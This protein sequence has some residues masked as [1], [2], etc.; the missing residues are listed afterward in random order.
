[1]QDLY[2]SLGLCK[3]AKVNQQ[4]G[5]QLSRMGRQATY[6]DI[7]FSSRWGTGGAAV[8]DKCIKRDFFRG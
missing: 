1:M 8:S 5:V 3:I 4:I 6:K 7:Q 2:R